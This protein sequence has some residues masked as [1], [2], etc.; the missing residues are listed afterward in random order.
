M[1]TMQLYNQSFKYSKSLTVVAM[2]ITVLNLALFNL[3]YANNIIAKF[4]RLTASNQETF[5]GVAIT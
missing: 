4:S 3:C 1:Q 5:N 2:T